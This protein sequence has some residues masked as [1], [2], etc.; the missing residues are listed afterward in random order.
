VLGDEAIDG[1]LEIGGGSEH[2]ALQAPLGELGE[3]AFDRVKPGAEVGAKWK[4]SADDVGAIAAPWG[5]F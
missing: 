4:A 3:E 2:P 5:A 1:G